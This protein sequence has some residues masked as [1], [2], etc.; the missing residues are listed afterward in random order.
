MAFTAMATTNSFL[1]SNNYR[2][3]LCFS[4]Y[5][6]HYCANIGR[7]Y[8]LIGLVASLLLTFE[9]HH[10]KH[11]LLAVYILPLNPKSLK[12]LHAKSLIHVQQYDYQLL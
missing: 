6:C 10:L 7:P 11:G 2:A 1:L 5:T 12:V 4:I 9:R 3:S 8:F